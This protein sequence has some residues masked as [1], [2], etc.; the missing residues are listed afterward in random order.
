MTATSLP[1]VDATLLQRLARMRDGGGVVTVLAARGEASETEIRS[2]LRR[3]G[4]VARA[5]AEEA[6]A[7]ANPHLDGPAHGIVAAL[8]T[9]EVY[10]FT[11]PRPVETLVTFASRP[12]VVPIARAHDAARPVGIV[13]ARLERVRIVESVN[14]QAHELEGTSLAS[15]HD[16][17]EFSG[18]ARANP[19]RGIESSVQTERYDRRVRVQR[20]RALTDAARHIS[21]LAR[22]RS[23]RAIMIA[24]DPHVTGDLAAKLP[25]GMRV[26]RHLPEWESA[27]KLVVELAGELDAARQQAT[28]TRTAVA[29]AR[30]LAFAIGAVA[31]R[32][33]IDDGRARATIVDGSSLEA[34]E[35]GAIV[36]HSLAHEVDVFFADGHLGN[37]AGVVCELHGAP[38]A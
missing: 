37:L 20:T 25:S 15:A 31:G 8:S 38:G 26:D 5:L 10:R 16:W 4:E 9:D 28:A 13:D 17:T 34:E 19:L 23:W 6:A 18:P 21:E 12:D 32:S 11:M 3:T 2:T 22:Q 29:H 7:L 27:G 35:L 24:G 33:A 36:R 1:Y 14:G 30:P